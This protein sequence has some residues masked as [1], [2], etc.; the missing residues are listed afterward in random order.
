M[1]PFEIDVMGQT[2]LIKYMLTI[3][4]HNLHI[5]SNYVTGG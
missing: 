3:D 2:N 1:L 4:T 5:F